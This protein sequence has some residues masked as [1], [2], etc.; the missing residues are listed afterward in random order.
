MHAEIAATV[1]R[2][3][4]PGLSSAACS[5]L[6][7]ALGRSPTVLE[8]EVYAA[9]LRVHAGDAE[10]PGPP[11]LALTAGGAAVLA[12]AQGRGAVVASAL[13]LA[14]GGAQPL[15]VLLESSAA[16]ELEPPA[17]GFGS[18]PR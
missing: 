12:V 10:A 17:D 7:A 1:A 5:H 18:P 8:L 3:H 2:E 11:R 14:A 15:A 6:E 16:G 4:T 9:L 13:E